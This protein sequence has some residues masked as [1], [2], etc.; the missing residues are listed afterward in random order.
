MRKTLAI[1]FIM[2]FSIGAANY[3]MLHSKV[4]N[5]ISTD[6]RN[7]G[8][9]VYVHYEWYVNPKKLVFD[10]REVPLDKSAMDVSRVLLQ[11]SEA[12]KDK[13]FESVILAHNGNGKF[14][15]KGAFFKLT[16]Q[17]YGTQ[18]PIYTLRTLPQNVYNLDGTKAFPTWTGGILGVMGKQME[19]L[20]EFNKQWYLNSV[21]TSN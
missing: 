14:M 16:G 19:D 10:I 17:E 18:N 8:I 12:L 2:L 5:K 13:D 11:S 6:D 3:F 9:E 20:S 4:A 21:I 7:H 1:I 15:L